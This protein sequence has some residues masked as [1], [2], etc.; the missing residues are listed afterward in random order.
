MVR[1][2]SILEKYF[3][4]IK[5]FYSLISQIDLAT[6]ELSY[7]PY[8]DNF[9]VQLC[10]YLGNSIVRIFEP[11]AQGKYG[12][13]DWVFTDSETMGIYGYIE[14]K[15]FSP[16][17]RINISEFQNQVSKYLKLG[18]P[19][20]LTD[21]IEFAYYDSN[22]HVNC[23]SLLNK[24]IDWD[25]PSFNLETISYF[26]QFFSKIGFRP[27]SEQLVITELS[28]RAK[29][30]CE[31][32]VELLALEENEAD[33]E[34]E[35]N[36]IKALK[37]LWDNAAINLDTSLSNNKIFAGFISQILAFGLLYAHKF[38]DNSNILPSQKYELLHFFWNLKPYKQYSKNVEPFVHLFNTLSEE[39]ESKLSKIGAWYDNTRRFLSY[40]KID[41]NRTDKPNFHQL[42]ETFLQ[43]Y[44]K[45]TRIDFGAWYTPTYLADF[46]TKLTVKQIQNNKELKESL[47]NPYKI[48]DPCCG[49]GTFLESILEYVPFPSNSIISGFEVLPVP[50]ALANY[51][52][53]LFSIPDDIAVS[54]HLT[55]TLGNNT[56]SKPVFDLE[57]LDYIGK[58]FANEQIASYYL[59]KPP[60]TIIIGNPPCSDSSATNAGSFLEKLMEDF[61]PEVRKGRQNTQMQLNNEWIKFLRWATYKAMESKPSMIS[62]I[63][64]SSFLANISFKFAR[65]YLVENANEISIIEFDTDNRI[66]SDNQNVFN[67]LQ[68]RAIIFIS[69]YS[70]EK[71]SYVKYKDIRDLSKSAKQDFFNSEL[72]SIT[73]EILPID[74]QYS[75]RSIKEYNVEL[76]KTFYPLY[77]E[78]NEKEG[79][80][81]RHCSGVKL[82]PTHLLVHFSKGQLSR[83]NKYIGDI[84]HSY[85]DIKDRWY[86]GQVKPPS[87]KK[88]TPSVREALLTGYK[89]SRRYSFRPFLEAYVN[90]DLNL[91]TSLISTQGGGMRFRPEVRAAFSN[92]DVFGFAVAP[93]PAEISRKI[94][95]FCSF[96]WNLPDNDLASRGNAHIFCNK[97]PI[98]KKGR[99]W[100]STPI[101]NIN[102]KIIDNLS[103]LFKVSKETIQNQ[104][105]YYSYAILTSQHFLDTFAPI[106]HSLAGSTPSIPI[107]IHK[108]L[109]ENL[110]LL[111][112]KLANLEKDNYIFT[113]EDENL[114]QN[115]RW[116][117]SYKEFILSSYKITDI[118]IEFVLPNGEVM[119]QPVDYD[120]S[121]FNVSGYNVI[122]EWLKY[123]SFAYFRKEISI[124]EIN[125]L[126]SLIKRIR[127]Y[128]NLYDSLDEL[129]KNVLN[130]NLLK[131]G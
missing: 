92:E 45:D 38:I 78:E 47:N 113:K 46:I 51:R 59:S 88:I 114:T 65:K 117:N 5:E 68:G 103:K 111:G 40:V 119:I 130:S 73:W 17:E 9:F 121:Q 21:G 89:I 19:V 84:E 104:I 30:L 97:F 34:H 126:L 25:N 86:S 99:F 61:R 63:L 79:I 12:R 101:S 41:N 32:L 81:I 43:T 15:G 106:L 31:E 49:T 58:F 28:K 54:V 71:V 20:L 122:R 70:K 22:G 29:L 102:T 1:Y 57:K 116:N 36:T 42:Y 95:K 2:K 62:F 4:E 96:C 56:F 115:I 50:Y 23:F 74:Q 109:F 107:T 35:L 124:N 105:V 14:A 123:H 69:F 27:I 100:D 127:L 82:A 85:K 8:L 67:T 16:F 6:D 120:V 108:E 80:F 129:V 110:S 131:L 93:A 3:N 75:F 64:P 26:E 98:Y 48:L 53:S 10:Q 91:L 44:D 52:L 83:R 24:P 13:P 118:G 112:K 87:E 55:N 90:D 37:R 60:L 18:N 128:L 94:S 125:N 66:E 39:L 33:S 7:R 11:R 72:N 77:S 76:Y